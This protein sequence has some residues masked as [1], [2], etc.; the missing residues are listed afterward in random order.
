MERTPCYGNC[1]LLNGYSQSPIDD[2]WGAQSIAP[3][4]QQLTQKVAQETKTANRV[5][6]CAGAGAIAF[7]PVTTL[8]DAGD[9][10]S[11]LAG[12]GTD[13]AEKGLGVLSD[14]KVLSRGVRVGSKYLG[15]AAGVVG[16]GLAVHGPTKT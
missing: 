15:K 4:A 14:V 6:D 13:A 3:F 9:V 8:G 12:Q 7:S 2:S 5:A 10:S 1:D 11:A 16:K